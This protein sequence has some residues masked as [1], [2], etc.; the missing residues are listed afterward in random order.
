[1]KHGLKMVVLAMVFN[2]L[3]IGSGL[4]VAIKH[5]K[6]VSSKLRDGMFKKAG[7]ILCY[8]MAWLIDNFG[9]TVGF[10]V[11]VK[12]LPIIVMYAIVT[13]VV[14]VIENISQLNPDLLPYKLL[15]IFN[16]NS[17]LNLIK[18][19]TGNESSKNDQVGA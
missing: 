19:E 6:V 18:K 13:E 7:F 4:L 2:G 14:S 17:D 10:T 8:L 5:R 15:E 16:I 3:D 9:G 1:M 11:G 12:I